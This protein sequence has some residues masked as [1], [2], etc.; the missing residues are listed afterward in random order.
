LIDKI[1]KYEKIFDKEKIDI[2]HFFTVFYFKKTRELFN[3]IKR[4]IIENN[5][6]G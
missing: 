5:N 6:R 3:F 2:N 4:V 1:L